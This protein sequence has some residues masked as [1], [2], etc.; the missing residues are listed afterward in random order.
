MN[1][2]KIVK[3]QLPIEWLIEQLINHPD[4]NIEILKEIIK[5]K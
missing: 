5:N 1:T 2:S 3:Q 4:F